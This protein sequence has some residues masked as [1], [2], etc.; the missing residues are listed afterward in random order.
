[1]KQQDE[2]YSIFCYRFHWPRGVVVWLAHLI[3][4]HLSMPRPTMIV[5]VLFIAFTV[6]VKNATCH[7]PNTSW[8]IPSYGLWSWSPRLHPIIQSPILYSMN[9]FYFGGLA[10][11]SSMYLL[12]AALYIIMSPLV[13]CFLQ[14]LTLL[15]RHTLSSF[16]FPF[17][18]LK[19]FFFFF[20]FI[21]YV[22]MVSFLRVISVTSFLPFFTFSVICLGVFYQFFAPSLP[23][24][25]NTLGWIFNGRDFLSDSHVLV[26][27]LFP[28]T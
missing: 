2:T 15:E 3:Y 4:Q 18:A 24:D 11:C 27:F 20:F 25:I 19:L 9:L 14:F 28:Y 6:F 17:I 1:M 16:F 7:P 10:R 26:S 12:R 23:P 21:V 13:C 22:L 5:M 8:P